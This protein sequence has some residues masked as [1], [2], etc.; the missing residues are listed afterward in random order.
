MDTSAKLAE[1]HAGLRNEVPAHII[2]NGCPACAAGVEVERNGGR[3][4]DVCLS[5]GEVN[6]NERCPS[7]ERDCGHHCN[8]SWTH[9]RCDWCGK[10]W[11]ES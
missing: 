10:T 6:E 11:D 7:S 8:H 5:C 1:H 2:V 9:D 3:F 4:E